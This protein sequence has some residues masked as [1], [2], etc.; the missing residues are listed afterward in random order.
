VFVRGVRLL[1]LLELPPNVVVVVFGPAALKTEETVLA[2]ELA[3]PT[4]L[5]K[6]PCIDSVSSPRGA[7][8][9][10]SAEQET[11]SPVCE[12]GPLSSRDVGVVEAS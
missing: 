5:S 4:P 12:G 7:R 9:S 2:C 10:V 8:V 1:M 11:V 6:S 3:D